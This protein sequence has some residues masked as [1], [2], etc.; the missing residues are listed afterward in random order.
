M[1]FKGSKAAAIATQRTHSEA[2][3]SRVANGERTMRQQAHAL[4]DNDAR[5]GLAQEQMRRMKNR[6][7]SNQYGSTGHWERPPS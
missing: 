4:S 2:A 5:L 7:R 3:L 6:K 1:P